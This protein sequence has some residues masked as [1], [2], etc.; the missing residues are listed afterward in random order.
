MAVGAQRMLRYQ[1]QVVRDKIENL[2]IPEPACR[3]A[4]GIEAVDVVQDDGLIAVLVSL[5]VDAKGGG[6]AAD[7]AD[8]SAQRLADT[9]AFA[10]TGL[11]E[12]HQ[13]VQMSLGKGADILLQLGEGRHA[14]SV[15]R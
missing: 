14:D 11:A 12:D 10:D 2:L 6:L 8:F 3:L 1:V 4:V 9:A 5:E 15:G 7:P 13:Q